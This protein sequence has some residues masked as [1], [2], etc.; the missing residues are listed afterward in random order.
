MPIKQEKVSLQNVDIVI[1]S[2]L[3]YR[4]EHARNY[5]AWGL[6]DVFLLPFINPHG[7]RSC[8]GDS[9]KE[10]PNIFH[11]Y[12]TEFESFN[13]ILVTKS[14]PN[15][16][17]IV[18]TMKVSHFVKDRLKPQDFTRFFPVPVRWEFRRS[19][20]PSRGCL[21]CPSVVILDSQSLKTT[22]RGGT[23]G[24]DG[25]KRVKGRKRHL[26]VDTLGMVVAR[27]GR[28]RQCVGPTRG[29]AANLP[30]YNP[31]SRASGR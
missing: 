14:D 22:E 20:S 18:E 17:A 24:F 28:S 29:G 26:L 5:P 15:I 4:H 25:H 2:N 8:M 27:S 21:T 9:V 11:H 3:K 30:A 23:R 12:K 31:D 7:R 19:T 13:K 6:D 1:L 16:E 10:G